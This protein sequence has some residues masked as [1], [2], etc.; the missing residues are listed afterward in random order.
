M[1]RRHEDAIPHGH[2][3][4]VI[5]CSHMEFPLLVW[6]PREGGTVFKSNAGSS[7]LN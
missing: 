4:P 6:L 2:E 7:P 5:R 1:E 3:V